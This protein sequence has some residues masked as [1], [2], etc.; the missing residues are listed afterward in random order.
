M[1]S[2]LSPLRL[3]CALSVWELAT[4]IRDWNDVV[5]LVQRVFRGEILIPPEAQDDLGP[6]RGLHNGLNIGRPLKLHCVLPPGGNDAA[7]PDND[8]PDPAVIIRPNWVGVLIKFLWVRRTQ[9][10][11]VQHIKRFKA[12]PSRERY[13][14]AN[15]IILPRF[16]GTYVVQLSHTFEVDYRPIVSIFHAA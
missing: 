2:D 16:I 3:D 14:P 12:P 15:A 9:G 10:E 5:R 4:E 8:F 11:C 1:L 7:G 6:A 13:A